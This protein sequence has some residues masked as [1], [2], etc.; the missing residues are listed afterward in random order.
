MMAIFF[1]HTDLIDFVVFKRDTEGVLRGKCK[2]CRPGKCCEYRIQQSDG[3]TRTTCDCGHSNFHHEL[4]EDS[5]EYRQSL[6]TPM[7]AQS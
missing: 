5:R 1:F 4:I 3:S 7:D 2:L 6:V